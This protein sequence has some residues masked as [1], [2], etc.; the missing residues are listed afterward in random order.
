MNSKF[1]YLQWT[2]WI[3]EEFKN[4]KHKLL[5]VGE[6][7]YAQIGTEFSQEVYDEFMSDRA[8]TKYVIARSLKGEVWAT[9]RNLA[10]LLLDAPDNDAAHLWPYVAFYN[11]IQ[12]PMKSRKERP[13]KDDFIKA[14]EGFAQLIE[15]IEVDYCLFLG[16][17]MIHEFDRKI[18]GDDTIELTDREADRLAKNWYHFRELKKGDR[19]IKIFFIK[20]PGMAF[21]WNKWK[22]FL[23][24]K[25]KTLVEMLN[26]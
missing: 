17:T 22:E 21:S 13:S 15:D 6:S 2:P 3:G 14:Y 8:S 19:I 1:E 24:G 11:Y 25:D 18:K 5:I 20:H 23:R 12:R 7:H 10:K 9:F 4:E 16:A 26:K